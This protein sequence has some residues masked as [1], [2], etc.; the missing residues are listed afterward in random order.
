MKKII[1]LVLALTMA[2]SMTACGGSGEA[3]GQEQEKVKKNPVRS[4]LYDES[5]RLLAD[6][7]YE[8][9]ENG[10]RLSNTTDWCANDELEKEKN[11]S[12]TGK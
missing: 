2:V 5:G 1:A 9:D 11:V 4:E 6:I 7:S 8:Y 3:G 10:R 12:P